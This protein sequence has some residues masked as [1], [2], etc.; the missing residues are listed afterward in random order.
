MKFGLTVVTTVAA[1][2]MWSGGTG[3][4]TVAAARSGL[5]FGACP[6][7]SG[8][9]PG[10]GTQ[11]ATVS[12]PMDYADPHGRQIQLTVSR[13][14]ATGTRHGV[15]FI[16]PGGPGADALGYWTEPTAIF[17]ADLTEHFDRIAVQPRG[18]RWSTPLNCAAPPSRPPQPESRSGIKSA[19]DAT[20]PGYIETITTE[21]T[22]R[23]MDA[24]RAALGVPAIDFIGQSYGTYLAAVYATL[25]PQHVDKLVLDS[26]VDP[27]WIWTEEFAQQQLAGESR[28]NDLF[29]WIAAHNDRYRLGDTPLQVYLLWSA[30]VSKQGGGWYANLTPPPA[31]PDDL[32]VAAREEVTASI[33]AAF[34][35]ALDGAS[36]LQ[37]LVRGLASDYES[38]NVPLVAATDVATNTRLFWPI[39]ATAMAQT[40]EDPRH[41]ELLNDIVGNTPEDPTSQ[42]VFAAVTCNENATPS[43]PD[44]FGAAL[45][46]ITVGGSALDARAD[47]VRTGFACLGW[48]TSATPVRPDGAKLHTRPLL[49][50]SVHDAETSYTGGPAMARAMNG[51]LITVGGGDH[52]DFGRGN[53]SVDSAVT[54]YLET[55]K[56]SIS[57][58]PEA[59]L[60]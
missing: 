9:L 52:G 21:N 31:Q 32:P 53:T 7:N 60:P 47:L 36:R 55:G 6:A 15:V 14:P 54:T 20:Q 13:V 50:Q 1:L 10:S 17:P 40:A 3:W 57:H 35:G 51:N 19:C 39:F 58:A 26:N 43:R 59:P 12:V 49:L 30:L 45:A 23:D 29:T 46:I 22:A 37:N 41:T 28:Y 18:L 2:G 25:F 16:N 42:Y 38:W 34:D 56:V 44:L 33:R 8:V 11:C 48:P 27:D 5:D 24:V 4:S